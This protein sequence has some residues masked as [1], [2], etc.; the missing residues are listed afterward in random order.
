MTGENN[1]SYEKDLVM[2]DDHKFEV[3]FEPNVYELT[4][5]SEKAMFLPLKVIFMK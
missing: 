5:T 4:I 3:E 1:S 2:N